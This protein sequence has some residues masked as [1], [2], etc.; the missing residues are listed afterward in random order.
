MQNNA[1][2]AEFMS[3]MFKAKSGGFTKKDFFRKSFSQYFKS[4]EYSNELV[5]RMVSELQNPS[6]NIPENFIAFY[7]ENKKLLYEDIKNNL[8]PSMYLAD[9]DFSEKYTL[10]GENLADSIYFIICKNLRIP[11]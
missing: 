10:E 6:G 5:S 4:G 8:I 2:M 11:A 3:D 9:S 1:F 7:N